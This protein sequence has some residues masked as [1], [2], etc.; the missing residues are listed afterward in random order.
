MSAFEVQQ[1]LLFIQ[2]AG[3]PD[4]FSS[5]AAFAANELYISK[6]I[7]SISAISY[8]VYFRTTSYSD[9][10]LRVCAV[11]RRFSVYG[12]FGFFR[13]VSTCK[14]KKTYVIPFAPH[15]TQVACSL[16][17]FHSFVFFA[18]KRVYHFRVSFCF[19][20]FSIRYDCSSC[21]HTVWRKGRSKRN[22]KVIDP[23]TG[24]ETKEWNR[25]KEQAT[26][27]EC[28][29]KGITYVFFFLHV[30]TLRKK[31][32]CPYTENRRK[33]AQTRNSESE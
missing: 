19:C 20:L 7:R 12:H 5:S 21:N 33:T 9:S 10:L 16:S 2:S 31:P 13:N 4:Q 11:F 1:K 32:K 24:K 18:G 28:G 14:K 30:L 8:S 22:A 17:R 6:F 27:V 25:D 26:C 15:S 23:L 3:I 29:A